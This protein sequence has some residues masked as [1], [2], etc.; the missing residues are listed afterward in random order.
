LLTALLVS[1][2]SAGHIIKL[3]KVEKGSS[4]D[5]DV[6]EQAAEERMK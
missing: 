6:G 3:L 1:P 4:V 5:K 2:H